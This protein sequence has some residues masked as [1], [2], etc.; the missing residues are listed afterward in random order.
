MSQT[1]AKGFRELYGRLTPTREE[2]QAA[3]SHRNSIHEC[4]E[5]HFGPV[6]LFRTGSFGNGTSIRGRS[7]IDYFACIS[8]EKLKSNSSKTLQDVQKV[9]ST[10]F[11]NTK[12]REPAVVID[13]GDEA[14]RPAEIVPAKLIKQSAE[15]NFMF[16]GFINSWIARSNLS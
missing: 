15:G 12:I 3:K 6:R 14:S 2:S 16:V 8:A 13:F 5:K 4:L 10:R 1:V 11:P 9:L 7:D